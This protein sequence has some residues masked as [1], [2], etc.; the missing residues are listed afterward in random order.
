MRRRNRTYINRDTTG[1]STIELAPHKPSFLFGGR[2]RIRTF[3]AFP[4]PRVSN[5][6]PYHSA[7]LPNLEE[8]GGVEPL[9]FRT[10]RYSTPVAGQPSS[11]FLCT[12]PETNACLLPETIGAARWIRTTTIS[13]PRGYGPVL[14][15]SAIATTWCPRKESNLQKPDFE[16]GAF[17]NYTT[18][19]NLVRVV[20]VE[21][22]TTR[23]QAGNSTRLSYTLKLVPLH[24][25]EPR[26]FWF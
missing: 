13:R 19:A 25:F 4:P 22:T 17:A 8:S 5:P 6:V 26:T 12:L 10:L 11:A 7:T 3:A 24:G 18:R 15:H 14:C 20:G 21:P 1:G 23:V 16:S 2:R 9:T